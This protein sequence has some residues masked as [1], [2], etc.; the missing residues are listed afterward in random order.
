MSHR[1][2]YENGM[3]SF[4]TYIACNTKKDDNQHIEHKYQSLTILFIEMV[5]PAEKNARIRRGCS[6]I[7]Q[8]Y[9]AL[10]LLTMLPLAFVYVFDYLAS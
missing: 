8:I 1:L 2:Q 3:D 5:Y 4:L 10:L 6:I 7:Y 9:L